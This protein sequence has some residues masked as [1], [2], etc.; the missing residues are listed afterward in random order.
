MKASREANG[1]TPAEVIPHV[2]GARLPSGVPQ[3]LRTWKP[4][5]QQKAGLKPSMGWWER[6]C[7]RAV[8]AVGSPQSSEPHSR[9]LQDSSHETEELKRK[10]IRYPVIGRPPCCLIIL[11]W[12]LPVNKLC[13]HTVIP[14]ASQS[15]L[16]NTSEEPSIARYLRKV[17]NVKQIKN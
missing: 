4:K 12:G 7:Y 9:E 6:A 14:L 2:N 5:A 16:P 17:S 1:W 15:L 13:L 11:H 10:C 3:S 8:Q